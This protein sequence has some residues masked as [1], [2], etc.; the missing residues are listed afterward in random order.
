[1]LKPRLPRAAWLV[2]GLGLLS[3][4]LL[5]LALTVL[6]AEAVRSADERTGSL[7]QV[8]AEQTSRTVQ[9][10]DVRLQL[11]ILRLEAME[12]TGPL[13]DAGARAL[14]QAELRDLPFV[15][16]IWV[17]DAAGRI[18]RDSDVGN[19]GTSV[20][21]REYVRVYRREPAT[22][23]FI[24]PLVR[25]RSTGQW[26][27]SASR[28]VRAADG[29]FQGVITAAIEPPYFEQLWRGADLG[30]SGA[31][32]LYHR[33]GQMMMRS[34]A[35]ASTMGDSY[36]T[37]PLFQ[38]HLRNG[39]HGSFV[40][41]SPTD[42]V[43]RLVHYRVLAEYPQLVVA[44]GSGYEEV[45]APWRR[46][47]ALTGVVW[48]AAVLLTAG[49]TWQLLRHARSRARTERRFSELAQAMPQ[50]VFIADAAGR[51][52]FVSTRWTESTGLQPQQAL[53]LGWQEAVHPEDRDRTL[54]MLRRM[55][56]TGQELEHALRLRARAGGFRWHL[57]RAVPFH[58][59]G[60]PRP[61]WYGT[62]TDIDD[63]QQAQQRLHAQAEQLRLAGRLARLG[64]WRMDAATQRITWSEE[65][66]AMVDLPADG[67]PSIQEVVGL[68]QS[69]SVP[70]A[71]H[72]LQESI[73]H[74]KPFD[75][76]LEVL[77]PA[78]RRVW[79]RSIGEPV[80]DAQGRVVAMQGA[81]QDITQRMQL[82]EEIR[83]LNSGLEEKI[84]RRTRELSR[85]EALFRTL[86]EQAPWPFWTVD[87]QGAVTFFSRA[88][89][90][91]VGGEAPQWQGEKWM[92]LLHPDDLEP[93]RENWKKSRRE[94]SVYAGTRR[95]KARDGTYHTTSYRAA[96]VRNPEGEI[97]FWVGI[98]TDITDLTA[99]DAAL[100][101]ANKQL[102]AFAYSVSHD[103]QSPLQ[104]VLAFAKLLDEELAASPPDGRGR[105]YLARIRANAD[106]MTQ[107]IE[108]L[109]SLAHVS[110]LDII[111]SVVNL[112]DMAGEILQRLAQDD[113]QRQ[114]QWHVQ[115]GL[116]VVAD[117]R[118]MRSV[119]ENLLANAW[120]FTAQQPQ[121]RIEVGGSQQRGEYFVRDNGAGFDMAYADRLFGTFQRLHDA[122]QFPGTGIGLATVAR[123]ISRQ[124]GRIWAQAT[125]EA[126][127]T[128]FFTLPPA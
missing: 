2:I 1:M 123:A 72:A 67:T 25:S 15:R 64:P 66:A 126:G 127:A 88:W 41:R 16:A 83:R 28:P 36:A 75:V 99:N 81:Q 9:A 44:V 27:M 117:V 69:R 96:P 106:V 23:F 3:A 80:F 113:P 79:V 97:V 37:L 115:P 21:D 31:I 4:I 30:A 7:T 40:G 5:A 93:V 119:L 63:L 20:A 100:R 17:T 35:V 87:P 84:A 62:A 54:R 22:E 73:D 13:D 11:A 24:G 120:K 86:A 114:V 61:A 45:L 14:L 10:V 71:L 60:S 103:L 102:E 112:S 128:F 43:L 8:I 118:L 110:E 82:L 55:F 52:Q 19:I 51:V 38:Q 121:A 6:R 33:N 78:G 124:G 59:D 48:L 116:A 12:R 90:E 70:E 108:G 49:L 77:T 76:E 104:R 57:L 92:E 39:P 47:A 122:D 98:D 42:K 46:F 34:P 58:E 65:A 125:P 74:G 109:L 101:L 18:V 107:L 29:T 53:G 85:Q 105:H 32:V 50:I 94:G 68:L 95:L 26:L 89:Y 91:L 111:R 56:R